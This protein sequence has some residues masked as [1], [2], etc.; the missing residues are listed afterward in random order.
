MPAKQV[1]I[2]MNPVK[3]DDGRRKTERF[4]ERKITLA[5]QYIEKSSRK[6]AKPQRKT[7]WTSSEFFASLRLCVKTFF[8][9]ACFRV[10]RVFRGQICVLAWDLLVP[11]ST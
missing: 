11:V 3:S 8:R 7:E 5:S 2:T 4:D 1:M 9:A 6:G 10:F